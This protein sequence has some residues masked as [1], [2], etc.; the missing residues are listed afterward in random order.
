MA[1]KAAT[2]VQP[3]DI[4]IGGSPVLEA[5]SQPHPPP[6]EL[7]SGESADENSP[8]TSPQPVDN[9]PWAVSW[10]LAQRWWPFRGNQVE[11]NDDDDVEVVAHGR[12]AHLKEAR[13]VM[14]S[15]TAELRYGILQ[16][17]SS[18]FELVVMETALTNNPVRY[19]MALKTPTTR[20]H[21]PPPESIPPS[22]SPVAPPATPRIL[23]PVKQSFRAINPTTKWRLRLQDWMWGRQTPENHLYWQEKLPRGKVA[24]ITF[25]QWLPPR[26]SRTHGISRQM[27]AQELLDVTTNQLPTPAVVGIALETLAS[28]KQAVEDN[29]HMLNQWMG[30][31]DVDMIVVVATGGAVPIAMETMDRCL[32]TGNIRAQVEIIGG[33][34]YLLGPLVT[35]QRGVSREDATVLNE[36]DGYKTGDVG[37]VA[38]RLL[39]YNTK[40]TL[41]AHVNDAVV[42]PASAWAIGWSHPHLHRVVVSDNQ[43]LGELMAMVALVKNKGAPSDQG[44]VADMGGLTPEASAHPDMVSRK[45]IVSR[46]VRAG[47]DHL[48]HTTAVVTASHHPLVVSPVVEH[49]V[50][51]PANV[52][53]LAWRL[54]G[55]VEE[56]LEMPHIPHLT[57][58]ANLQR[59]L[60]RWNPT[61][62]VSREVRLAAVG[63]VVIEVEDM[64]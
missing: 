39:R 31:L 61:D 38:A 60:V 5:T 3:D 18:H 57:L 19:T 23:P 14:E 41:A 47:V 54:R 26:Y 53:S 36:W 29:V 20:F 32:A 9:P 44:V 58:L 42:V 49:P 59:H 8:Q 12:Q 30:H 40:I 43:F 6:L 4:T 16:V 28:A 46:W 55:L 2:E 17:F 37:E 24:V 63:I 64:L 34:G 62:K 15:S 52:Y 56:F 10:N 22:T 50:A 45:D 21:Q 13:L 25:N 48:Y 33:A 35:S 51:V 11:E 7:P 27:L 1:S